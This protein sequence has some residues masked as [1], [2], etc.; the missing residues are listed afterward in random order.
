MRKPD[1]VRPLVAAAAGALRRR[2]GEVRAKDPLTVPVEDE[3]RNAFDDALRALA[4]ERL[5]DKALE[6]VDLAT[7]GPTELKD[8]AMQ[9][10][11]LLESEPLTKQREKRR[12][13]RRSEARA[14]EEAAF[15]RVAT[16][17]R[18]IG[19]GFVTLAFLAGFGYLAFV[20]YG[21]WDAGNEVPIA[22][23]RPAISGI[24]SFDPAAKLPALG[25]PPA[26]LASMTETKPDRYVTDYASA[27]PP[28]R[29]LQLNEK[30]A[31]FERETSDQ[32]IVYTAPGIP[33][34]TT[35]EELGAVAIRAWGVGLE[36]RDNGV[37]LFVFPDAR[38][39][40]I[41][42]GYGLEGV[43]TDAKSKEITSTVI[44]PA[45]VRGDFAG[46]IEAGI[47]AILTTVRTAGFQARG[48]TPHELRIMQLEHDAPL[49]LLTLFVMATIFSLTRP[50]PSGSGSSSWSS[51][52]SSSDSS[53]SSS[54]SSSGS[55]FS[56]G[57]GSGGGG[58]S[59]DSW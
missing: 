29:A 42:V 44:K 20:A 11:Q 13:T 24:A 33:E 49:I 22:A 27:L 51:G 19:R 48:T 26:T 8:A 47:D 45:F 53:S 36:G 38:K 39:M 2:A 21:I 58:G 41:E 25:A 4:S 16:G 43:L 14:A 30:L 35:L 3:L 57:G 59:S 12:P 34:G 5:S 1:S 7:A 32:V 28:D 17:F 6:R 31:Q 23:P 52:S 37:I 50:R 18:W 56:G 46:G 10:M 54:S 15:E 55:S 9:L 40:R